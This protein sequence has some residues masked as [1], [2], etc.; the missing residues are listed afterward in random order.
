MFSAA[1]LILGLFEFLRM[2]WT[3]SRVSDFMILIRGMT[4]GGD[5]GFELVAGSRFEL[6]VAEEELPAEGNWFAKAWVM[7][8]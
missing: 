4:G 8:E 7:G 5:A 6:L 2:S 1:V 3:A